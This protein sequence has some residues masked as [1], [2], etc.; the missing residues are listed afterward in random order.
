MSYSLALR[1]LLG[2]RLELCEL[3]RGLDLLHQVLHTPAWPE[4]QLRLYKRDR[5]LYY[6]FEL[7]S[8]LDGLAG[9]VMSHVWYPEGHAYNVPFDQDGLDALTPEAL[10]EL[11]ETLLGTAAVSVTLVTPRPWTELQDEL[12]DAW[13][14]I[15]I[16]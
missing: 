13:G 2:S 9:E 14:P 8:S 12:V 3:E 10:D 1:A 4:R 5:S 16:S 15:G 11:Y 6:N 7:P